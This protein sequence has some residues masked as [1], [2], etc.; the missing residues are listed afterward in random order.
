MYVRVTKNV[1]LL[2]EAVEERRLLARRPEM[3]LL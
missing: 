2:V 1:H 3:L